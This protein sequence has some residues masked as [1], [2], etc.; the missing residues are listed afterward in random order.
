[1]LDRVCIPCSA[2]INE[3]VVRG[4]LNG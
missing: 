4:T 1:L 3:K 2:I